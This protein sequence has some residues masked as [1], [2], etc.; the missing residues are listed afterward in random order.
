MHRH[1]HSG[2]ARWSALEALLASARATHQA[3]LMGHLNPVGTLL[4]PDWQFARTDS[5]I[6]VEG[7]A[8]FV[9]QRLFADVPLAYLCALQFA[10]HDV[11]QPIWLDPPDGIE[12]RLLPLGAPQHPLANR[13]TGWLDLG[14]VYGLS[15]LEGDVSMQLRRS[16][17][18]PWAP[19]KFLTA[20]G[21]VL[22]L[23]DTVSGKGAMFRDDCKVQSSFEACL[24]LG[25][26]MIQVKFCS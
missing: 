13:N 25:L 1:G 3:R 14:S 9:P 2:A 20:Q 19:A 8:R 22:R 26:R 7:L 17:N 21:D 16:L 18:D 10:Y 6:D 15:A 23:H 4:P 5:H 11:F 12:A 24:S